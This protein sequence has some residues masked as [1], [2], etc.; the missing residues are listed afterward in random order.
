[1]PRFLLDTNHL[2][3]AL[4][5]V[6]RLRDR[7]R[8]ACRT[9]T[10]VGT[11]V[12]VLCELEAGLL[13]IHDYEAY[14][15]SLAQLLKDVRVWPLE[16]RVVRHYGQLYHELKTKGRIL[17]QVDMMLA[18]LARLM[19]LTLLTSDRDFEALPDIRVENWLA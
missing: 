12:P 11:C 1:M 19:N 2:S 7:I 15:R 18:A 17:S 9:G 10:R 4:Q 8:Q 16:S 14:Q 5:R 6:S 13:Q 3:A